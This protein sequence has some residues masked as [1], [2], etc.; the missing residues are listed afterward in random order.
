MRWPDLSERCRALS[1]DDAQIAQ[2]ITALEE[3]AREWLN[4]L[5]A[6]QAFGVHITPVIEPAIE[7]PPA[8]PEPERAPNPEPA[9]PAP[10]KQRMVKTSTAPQA[11]PPQPEKEAP[12][13]RDAAADEA[14]LAQL[15]PEIANA[16]RVRRRLLGPSADIRKLI[17]E[18]EAGSGSK[19]DGKRE[20][21]RKNTWWR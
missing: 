15:D 16:V 14:L 19:R 20:R 1:E 7:A 2:A 10:V 12:A 11:P 8:E 9:P 4:E 18:A 5:G 6:L 13:E 21:N 3:K 17:A